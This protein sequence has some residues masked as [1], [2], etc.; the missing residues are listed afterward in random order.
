MTEINANQLKYIFM[1]MD[2]AVCATKI[3]GELIYANPAA[4]ELFGLSGEETSKL[5]KAIPLVEENDAL[6]QLFIDGIMKK[7]KSF[8]SLVD[9]VNRDGK[10][11]HLHVSLTCES[12]DSGM[13]L[14]VVS[15]LTRMVKVRSAFARYTSKDIAEYVLTSPDGEKQ[16]GTD[17]EV[18]ILM[19][20]LRGFTMLST[21]L[22]SSDLITMLN[23]YFEC[24]SNVIDRYGGTVIE[25]LGDGIFVVFGAPKEMS[26][27]ASAAVSCAVGMQNAMAEVNAW[28]R[29]HG[30]PEL[31]MGIGIHSGTTVVGNIGSEKRMKYGC[32]GEAVNLAGRLEQYTV[33]GQV[34]VSEAT[35]GRIPEPLHVADEKSFMP[36]GA[37][38][39]LKFY[40]VTGIGGEQILARSSGPEAWTPLPAETEI[41]F[42]VLD[43][44]TVET[45]RMAGRITR[46]S[47]DEKY[48][49]LATGSTLQPLQNLMFRV[50]PAD[51]YAKVLGREEKEYRLCFTA[52]PDRL[53]DLLQ[54]L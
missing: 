38:K 32:M 18:S 25:F 49:T 36:K 30:F 27:H 45:N 24:M 33:G 41:P 48:G 53:T 6:I 13:F 8:R 2:D 35:A 14:I 5:W 43:G 15:D 42:F 1:N 39:E 50:G 46:I 52:K 47:T 54:S 34:F 28:N 10:R 26:A 44:K 40:D 31:E 12:E 4:R 11:F 21:R 9:Y 37:R 17:R 19:S 16:G 20:D 7:K 29:E 3:N 22:S 51:I 23:H